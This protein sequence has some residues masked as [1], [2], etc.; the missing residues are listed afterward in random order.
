[1]YFY[2]KTFYFGNFLYTAPGKPGGPRLY[3]GAGPPWPHAGYGPADIQCIEDIQ[4]MSI[5]I[6]DVNSKNNEIEV[7]GKTP[8]FRELPLLV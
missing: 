8:G 4:Y 3:Q 1:M 6:Y 5:Q 2:W 7:K